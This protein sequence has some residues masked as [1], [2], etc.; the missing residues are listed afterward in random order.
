M[1]DSSSESFNSFESDMALFKLSLFLSCI[2]CMVSRCC[3]GL[4]KR[5]TKSLFCTC[6]DSDCSL[7]LCCRAS[8]LSDYSAI[9]FCNLPILDSRSNS[10]WMSSRERPRLCPPPRFLT[11]FG[12][13]LGSGFLN[14]KCLFLNS[15]EAVKFVGFT[16]CMPAAFDLSTLLLR[17]EFAPLPSDCLLRVS[18]ICSCPGNTEEVTSFGN[19]VPWLESWC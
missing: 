16:T 5:S 17:F 7:K 2:C 13:L 4:L 15:W 3:F 6:V 10:R 14:I 19:D 1:D 12:T 8:P 11:G 9:A 18:P